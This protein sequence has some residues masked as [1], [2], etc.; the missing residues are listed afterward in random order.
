MVRVV[1]D[2]VVVVSERH[3]GLVLL[4]ALGRQLWT[5]GEFERKVKG[6]SV[7]GLDCT[8]AIDFVTRKRAKGAEKLANLRAIC[9]WLEWLCVEACKSG[10]NGRIEL[11][12][13]AF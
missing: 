7:S 9:C 3:L 11:I 8:L 1:G 13:V 12:L 5:A 4:T 2:F 6:K 10:L